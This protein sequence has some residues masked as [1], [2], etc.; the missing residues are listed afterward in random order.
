MLDNLMIEIQ[1][2]TDMVKD[3]KQKENIDDEAL[4]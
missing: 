1:S 4:K 3:V 2:K